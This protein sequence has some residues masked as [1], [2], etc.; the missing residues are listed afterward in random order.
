[1]GELGEGVGEA[2]E[3]CVWAQKTVFIALWSKFQTQTVDPSNV[4]IVL[5]IS[6]G[7]VCPRRLNQMRDKLSRWE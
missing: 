6:D 5:G 4:F 7:S 3:N 1:M 2:S